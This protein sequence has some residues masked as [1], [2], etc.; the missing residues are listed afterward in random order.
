[1]WQCCKINICSSKKNSLD[2]FIPF[3][4]KEHWDHYPKCGWQL[5]WK[6]FFACA[7]SPFIS[8]SPLILFYFFHLAGSILHKKIIL[9]DNF[10]KKIAL[11]KIIKS[12]EESVSRENFRCLEWSIHRFT[13]ILMQPSSSTL[14]IIQ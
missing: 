10:H 9:F 8:L 11:Y 7:L 12:W 5:T 6:S 14:C 1:M 2:M 4:N 3:I 13:Y